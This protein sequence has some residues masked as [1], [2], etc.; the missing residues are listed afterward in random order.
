MMTWGVFDSLPLIVSAVLLAY[1]IVIVV[2]LINDGRDPTAT[3]TWVVLLTVL[4][5]L[6]L[7]LYF[8]FGRNWE[9]KTMR[10]RWARTIP[11]VMKPTLQRIHERYSAEA[12]EATSWSIEKGYGDL[13]RLIQT[14]DGAI[15]LPA[16][17]VDIITSGRDKFD[18]LI[19]DLAHARDTINLQYFIWERDEL[20]A[21]ITD[22][23]L[24]RI[25]AGV[26]VRI[27]N[28]F[29]GNIQ[30]RK[31]EMRRLRTAGARVRYDVT[32]LG[33]VNYR[34][35]QKIAVIDGAIGYTG[36][37][38]VG[39][40]YI[41]GGRRFPAWRDTHV[42]FTG[43]AVADLQKLFARPWH[44]QTGESLFC[45]RFFPL[46]Y[47]TGSVSSPA[48]VVST[49]A[50]N[51]W[52]PAR[53]AHVVA[54]GLAR[55]TLWIQSPYFVPDDAL[56]EAIVNVALSGVDVRLMLS[57]L[58]DKKIVWYAAES[59]FRPILEAG[60]RI[61]HYQAGFM[62]AKTMTVDGTLCSIGTMNLDVRSLQLH[63]ELMVWFYDAELAGRHD[64]IFEADLEHCEEYTIERLDSLTPLRVF[65]DSAARLISDLL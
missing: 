42:R 8:F 32:D 20:T 36:G 13:T 29:I 33:K 11:G 62:H 7:I 2:V 44:R 48:Q 14:T 45:E 30:Y 57:G 54:M 16:Y 6:G 31:D 26:E 3:V 41:D 55:D 37:M 53:R 35:H 10:S 24:D 18:K 19:A 27:L 39:Q 47:P 64:R 34:D 23:L 1:W 4:P 61:F 63:K 22:V 28:D 46:E 12:S 58:A 25:A 15:P 50:E 65:R 40:E 9:K 60:G 17:D 49:A 38:N 52:E 56:N 59:Y 21:R 43:P 5:G 51:P